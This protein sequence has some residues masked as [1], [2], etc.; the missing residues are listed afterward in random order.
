MA[1]NSRYAHALGAQAER[2]GAVGPG[3]LGQRRPVLLILAAYAAVGGGAT[4]VTLALGR[5]PFVCE[6]WLGIDGPAASLVSLG[7]G[8]CVGAI[9]I[10]ASRTLVR[11]VAWARALHEALRPAVRGADDGWLVAVALASAIGEELLF[12]G[13][14]VPALGVVV[15]SVVFGSLHQVR[16]PGRWGWIAWATVMGLLFGE[17]FAATGSLAGPLAAHLAINAANLRFLRDTDPA[18]RRPPLG[19]LLRRS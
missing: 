14:L 10:A 12:R 17:L 9:T 18:P 5:D 1:A 13:L 3:A 4:A 19:G 2:L 16:G 8:V 7:L 6:G 11:R 15:S